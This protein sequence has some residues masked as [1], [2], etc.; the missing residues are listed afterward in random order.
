MALGC[1]LS[2][3]AEKLTDREIKITHIEIPLDSDVWMKTK[4]A[5][6]EAGYKFF[7]QTNLFDPGRVNLFL[8]LRAPEPEGKLSHGFIVHDGGS[9][10]DSKIGEVYEQ[11]IAPNNGPR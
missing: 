3:L 2:E 4:H 7:F 11:E 6:R 9:A 8:E 1:T 10:I 5:L